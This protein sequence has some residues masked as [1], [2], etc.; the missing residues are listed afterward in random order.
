[1][2]LDED[3]APKGGGSEESLALPDVGGFGLGDQCGRVLW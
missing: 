2:I 3:A 1:M